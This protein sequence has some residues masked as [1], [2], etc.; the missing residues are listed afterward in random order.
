MKK[1]LKK[2]QAVSIQNPA[3]LFISGFFHPKSTIQNPTSNIILPPSKAKS[4]S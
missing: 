2:P 4:F 3:S 1:T